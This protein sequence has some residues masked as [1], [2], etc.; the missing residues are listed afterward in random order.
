MPRQYC[1]TIRYVLLVASVFVH[2]KA[3]PFKKSLSARYSVPPCS[4]LGATFTA[5]T[6]VFWPLRPTLWLRVSVITLTTK[7][8]GLCQSSDFTCMT[9]CTAE[10]NVPLSITAIDDRGKL[11]TFDWQFYAEVM[12]CEYEITP[13]IYRLYNELNFHVTSSTTSSDQHLQPLQ[14]FTILQVR[15]L[16]L[17]ST[18]LRRRYRR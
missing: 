5:A 13:T 16:V 6:R 18:T 2:S 12:Q 11:L 7:T 17:C 9:Y 14:L 3:L 4:Q 15:P 1:R 10:K 8:Y